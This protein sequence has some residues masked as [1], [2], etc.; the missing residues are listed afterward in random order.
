M[1][2]FRPRTLL[3]ALISAVA[4]ILPAQ[5]G[6]GED[7]L[8]TAELHAREAAASGSGAKWLVAGLY[9]LYAGDTE[10]AEAH[11]SRAAE[12]LPPA[13]AAEAAW[14]LA[15]GFY[16]RQAA[17]FL[18]KR[19]AL[20]PENYRLGW[21]VAMLYEEAGETETAMNKFIHLATQDFRELP[22]DPEVATG[23]LDAGLDVL[24][25][26]GFQ[27][28]FVPADAPDREQILASLVMVEEHYRVSRYGHESSNWG[29]RTYEDGRTVPKVP[30]PVWQLKAASAG[31]AMRLARELGLSARKR[32]QALLYQQG[33]RA[34]VAFDVYRDFARY[35]FGRAPAPVDFSSLAVEY[36]AE[37]EWLEYR[38][39]S[40]GASSKTSDQTAA[41]TTAGGTTRKPKRQKASGTNGQALIDFINIRHEENHYQTPAAVAQYQINRAVK[42]ASRDPR[43]L[44]RL[45]ESDSTWNWPRVPSSGEEVSRNES[46]LEETAR[47]IRDRC[48]TWSRPRDLL[49]A[50]I[51][52]SGS[53][54]LEYAL[55]LF[56]RAVAGAGDDHRLKEN[57]VRFLAR[58]N[59]KA[60]LELNAGLTPYERAGALQEAIEWKAGMPSA[61]LADVL[62]I[63]DLWLHELKQASEP[64]FQGHLSAVWE[65]DQKSAL[66][67]FERAWPDA[68]VVSFFRAQPRE[69]QVVQP[70]DPN[71]AE[72]KSQPSAD[73]IRES[74]SRRKTLLLEIYREL[75]RFPQASVLAFERLERAETVGIISRENRMEDAL[76]SLK[77]QTKGG[78]FL[79]NLAD[80]SPASSILEYAAAHPGWLE[81]KALPALAEAD[82]VRNFLQMCAPLF[83]AKEQD[84]IATAEAVAKKLSAEAWP[85]FFSQSLVILKRR[86]LIKFQPAL[87][88]R[89]GAVTGVPSLGGAAVEAARL[90]YDQGGASGLDQW[91]DQ[92]IVLP[93]GAAALARSAETSRGEAFSNLLLNTGLARSL[94][95]HPEF[96]DPAKPFHPRWPQQSAANETEL[97]RMLEMGGMLGDLPEFGCL[98]G[99]PLARMNG[100]L[101][102]SLRSLINYSG[103]MPDWKSLPQTFGV[104][105]ISAALEERRSERSSNR[106]L[107]VLGDHLEVIKTLSSARQQELA[108]CCNLSERSPDA[109]ASSPRLLEVWDWRCQQMEQWALD[110]YSRLSPMN[111]ADL[112]QEKQIVIS[113]SLP[114]WLFSADPAAAEKL[115]GRL[116]VTASL[117]TAYG[118]TSEFLNAASPDV[119]I[120]RLQHL[121]RLPEQDLYGGYEGTASYLLGEFLC[122]ESGSDLSRLDDVAQRLREAPALELPESYFPR[123]TIALLDSLTRGSRLSAEQYR[124][125]AGKIGAIQGECLLRKALAA[126]LRLAALDASRRVETELEAEFLCAAEMGLPEFRKTNH[127]DDRLRTSAETLTQDQE[128][129]LA[130]LTDDSIPVSQ[131]RRNAARACRMPAIWDYPLLRASLPLL[132]EFGEAPL[133]TAPSADRGED[134]A[135]AFAHAALLLAPHHQW[136]RDV[137]WRISKAVAR[138]TGPFRPQPRWLLLPIRSAPPGQLTSMIR[139]EAALRVKDRDRG[140]GD[141]LENVFRALLDIGA[142]EAA[143]ELI[144][145]D[146]ALLPGS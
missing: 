100:S 11:L 84:F 126:A 96:A 143:E 25:P 114:A 39:N 13:E 57:A 85:G 146:P 48:R 64:E 133:P 99:A 32:T 5:A 65:S 15:D 45:G 12:K 80:V 59:P 28:P 73:D 79:L 105:L 97:L 127:R 121:A 51:A 135:E 89:L 123:L 58:A 70:E 61:S 60:A 31:Q 95:R 62:D 87:M 30:G 132:E 19:A 117:A 108:M 104:R 106:I 118:F 40:A 6:E 44:M 103:K 9:S 86:G 37:R 136:Q 90:T 91:L 69:R 137:D 72:P 129:V 111:D 42:E 101:Y 47:I 22:F 113:T 68:G 4:G 17:R 109:Y 119:T 124:Q 3:I 50:A 24:T 66:E 76:L 98:P 141:R 78:M 46:D 53:G 33:V 16:A 93:G 134:S 120:R 71:P 83:A 92:M 34:A 14:V 131:R 130:Y 2:R 10:R 115:A 142:F 8:K 26:T 144:Q 116:L 81:T 122:W 138:I 63:A 77:M 94:H 29:Y 74:A 82:Y 35:G 56:E 125:T 41:A 1:K 107:T 20:H 54:E 21:M 145:L 55:P 23:T 36:P 43:R 7:F 112:E 102:S 140:T 18:E 88:L 128:L 52:I 27:E 49:A 75:L 110:E 67:V 139:T 38:K